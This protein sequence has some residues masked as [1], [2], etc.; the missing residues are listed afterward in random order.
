MNSLVY[1]ERHNIDHL[2][3][4]KAIEEAA[5]G[6]VYAKSFLLDLM[7]PN[8][9]ALIMNDYEMVMPLTWRKKYG[10]SYLYQPPF[11]QQLGVFGNKIRDH[12]PEFLHMAKNQFPF[13]EIQLNHQHADA[14]GEP[15]QNFF[16]DLNRS[17][18]D[19]AAS[20]APVHQKNLKRAANASL[21]YVSSHRYKA[22]IELN[23]SLYGQKS[24]LQ[25]HAYKQL[26]VLAQQNPSQVLVREVW[27]EQECQASAFCLKDHRRIYFLLSAVTPAGKK[28]QANHF[29]VDQLIHEFSGRPVILDFE[30]SDIAGIAAF[31]KGFGAV[32]EPYYFCKWNHLPWPYRLFKR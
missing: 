23:Y 21:H 4:D 28:S 30:G 22:A 19:L 25:I 18:S 2:K 27:Q 11:L 9:S 20:Y 5:N 6:N 32:N 3:W 15:K 16:I 7:S 8:W 26:D 1:T 14:D 12:V 10:I 31:Y 17:Y 13:A 29:L 24:G